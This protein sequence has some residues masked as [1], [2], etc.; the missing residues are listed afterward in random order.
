MIIDAGSSVDANVSDATLSIGTANNSF[1]N[2]GTLQASNAGSLF[3]TGVGNNDNTLDN[4]LGTI[5]ALA[6]S[7]VEFRIINVNGGLLTTQGDGVL[8]ATGQGGQSFQDL[9]I[10]GNFVIE[11][12]NINA[13]FAGEI[14]NRQ[15]ITMNSTGSCLLYT[16]PSPRDS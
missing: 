3:L 14:E 5:Q 16:S 7:D 13:R 9:T 2:A 1:V 15:T 6:G 10:D 4:T 12:G 11:S 8:R